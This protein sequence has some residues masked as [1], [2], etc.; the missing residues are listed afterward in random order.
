MDT[1]FDLVEILK[2]STYN[3]YKCLVRKKIV[4]KLHKQRDIQNYKKR[5]KRKLKVKVSY[6]I[7]APIKKDQY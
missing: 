7:E 2:R 1:N 3:K 6:N 4:L 5:S